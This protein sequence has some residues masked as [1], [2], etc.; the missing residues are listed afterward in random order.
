MF[1]DA[2]IVQQMAEL[3]DKIILYSG[4]FDTAGSFVSDS[5]SYDATL[6]NFIA[7]GELVNKLS[8]EFRMTHEQIDWRKISAFRNIIAHDYFGTD[9]EEV[10]QIIRKHIPKLKEDLMGLV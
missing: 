3:I 2:L 9:E 10:W 8:P 6:M 4:D 1:K 5:K 7:I